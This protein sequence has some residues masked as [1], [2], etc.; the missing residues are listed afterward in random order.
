MAWINVFGAVLLNAFASFMLKL[1]SEP[2]FKLPSLAQPLVAFKNWPLFVGLVSYC[3][4]FVL[5]AFA[6][7][8]L[9]LGVVYPVLTSGAIALVVAIS[10]LW[11]KEPLS[12]TSITGVV[13]ILL[14]VVLITRQ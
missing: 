3:L 11:F 8:R 7:S 1:A 10:F 13:L 5:Y 2:P 14:G 4:A 12:L 6:V 9:P